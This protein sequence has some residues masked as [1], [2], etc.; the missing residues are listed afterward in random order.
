MKRLTAC[1]GLIA[2]LLFPL[3]ANA[4]SCVYHVI[5]R[6]HYTDANG[7]DHGCTVTQFSDCSVWT[8]CAG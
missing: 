6:Y 7:S 2:V 4:Q 3:A 1:F 5:T 8:A